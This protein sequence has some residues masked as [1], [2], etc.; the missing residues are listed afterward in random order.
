M[1]YELSPQCISKAEWKKNKK[2][3]EGMNRHTGKYDIKDNE[4]VVNECTTLLGGF[5]L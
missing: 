5:I 3:D 2:K 1:C 4:G